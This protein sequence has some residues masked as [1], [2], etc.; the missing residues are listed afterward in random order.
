[1]AISLI[2]Y[3]AYFGLK[4]KKF[5]LSRISSFVYFIYNYSFIQKLFACNIDSCIICLD[6]FNKNSKRNAIIYISTYLICGLLFFSLRYIFPG[7]DFPQAVVDQT[8]M[9]LKH[10]REILGIELPELK[11]T[12]GSFL[13]N[14]PHALS[15]TT[16]R[17]H[18]GDV[19]H[20]L[21]MAAASETAFSFASL[22]LIFILANKWSKDRLPLIW[23]CIFFSFSFLLSI[24]FTVNFLGAIVRYRSIILPFYWFLL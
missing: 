5:R 7:L 17:P 4:E 24:G 3:H 20:I 19:K 22:F 2:I 23:F 1:M 18:P 6:T 9:L 8:T 11:P 21:S 16:L 10:C 13:M 14:T 15:S 12:I